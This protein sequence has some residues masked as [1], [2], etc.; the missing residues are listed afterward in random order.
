MKET[1]KLS[2]SLFNLFNIAL[3]VAAVIFNLYII[4]EVFKIASK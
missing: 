2:K 4:I 3:I 1:N